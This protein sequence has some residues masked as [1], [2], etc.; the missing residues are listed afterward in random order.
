[1]T[2]VLL[3]WILEYLKRLWSPLGKM[4]AFASLRHK[5]SF[6]CFLISTAVIVITI[7]CSI[8]WPS[9]HPYLS[10]I[11]TALGNAFHFAHLCRQKCFVVKVIKFRSDAAVKKNMKS[12]I[13]ARRKS[14]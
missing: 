6:G 13:S 2:F 9:T 10:L 8:Q 1:M 7:I 5:R 4:H 14:K 12:K 11:E 3:V